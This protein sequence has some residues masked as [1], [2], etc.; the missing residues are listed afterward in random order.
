MNSPILATKLYMPISRNDYVRRSRLVE[1]LNGGLDRRLTLISASAGYGKTTL[2]S[3]WASSCGRSVAWLSL[4]EGDDDPVRFVTHLVAALQTVS[5]HIGAGVVHALRSAQPAAT[6]SLLTLLVN[7]IAS[8]S[9]SMVLVLDDYHRIGDER[10]A[11]AVS[12]LLEKLPPQLHLVIATR[13]N[14]QLPLS[15]LRVRGQL[16]ELRDADLRFTPDEA[17]AF[18][19]QVM[20]LRLSSDDIRALQTR[21]EGWIAGLQLAALSMQGRTDHRTFIRSFAGDHRYV[22]DYLVEEVLNRQPDHVRS[23]LLQTSILDRLHGPLCDAVTGQEDGSQRLKLLEQGN[24]FVIPLDD[25]RSWYRYHHL[26]GD[27]LAAYLREDMPG[28]AATLHRRASQWYEEHGSWDDAIRHAFAAA[29]GERAARLIE[30]AW[31]ELR[32]NRRETAALGWL[33]LLPDELVRCRPVLSVMYAWALLA[34]GQ[35]EGVPDRLRDAERL[36]VRPAELP[37]S[38]ASASADAVYADEAEFRRLPGAIAVYRAAYAQLQGDVP[39]TLHYARM[40]LELVPA[41][42]HLPRGAA[43]A[44]LGLAAWSSGDLKEAY[45]MFAEGMVSVQLSGNLSDVVGGSIALAE[46]RIAQ[47]R[48]RE[49]MRAY[50]RGLQLAA[51][52]GEPELRGTSDLFVGMAELHLEHNDLHA[53]EQCLHSCKEQEERTG[54]APHYRYRWYAVMARLRKAR[55][56]LDGAIELLEEAERLQ[57]SDFFPN[58]RPLG[59][60]KARVLLAQGRWR[61]ALDWSRE[62]NLSADDELHY[63]REYEHITMAGVQLAR[64]RSAPADGAVQEAMRLLDRLLQAAEVGERTG[65]AIEILIAQAMACQLLDDM[66]AALKKLGQALTLAE[67]ETYVRSFVDEGEP[68]AV[69]LVA[70]AQQGIAVR[71]ARSLLAAFD[72]STHRSISLAARREPLTERELDVLRLLATDLSGPEMAKELM[73]SLNTLRTHTKNIYDKLEVN[74]RRAAVR[75]SMELDLI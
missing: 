70:A 69:L 11:A 6:E 14:P 21:T 28:H 29:D 17:A 13:A 24:F 20:G 39:A 66:P 16:A 5:S 48:L 41:D 31:P 72:T 33:R 19:Q 3:E 74:N 67:P 18:L 55:G 8:T 25:K 62:L 71:Y 7:D 15:R 75:V 42:D 38:A 12:Y 51:D 46:I 47:G 2:V 73:V 54:V 64:H 57:A 40:V 58:V 30:L 32:Q 68:M 61:D 63:L 35:P 22:V 36:A 43:T 52:R 59:A 27:V 60:M 56:D 10:I 65:S 45:R 37:D 26:F 49:A 44:L 34:C 4:D 50:A 23:F 9:I 53:A 1:R